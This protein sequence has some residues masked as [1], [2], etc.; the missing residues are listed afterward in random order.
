MRR[1][2][3]FLWTLLV[4]LL[5]TDYIRAE[6]A[7]AEDVEE[8]QGDDAQGDDA[9]G[10]DGAAADEAEEE[11]QGDDAQQDVQDE[12]E[13]Q[14]AEENQEDDDYF[15]Y[16][17]EVCSDAVIQ[18]QDVV[19]SCDSPGTYYY[20]SGK[21]RNNE[22][23]TPGDKVK[24]QIK[25]YIADHDTIQQAGNY[26]ILDVYAS[27]SNTA[28]QHQIYQNAD[29]CSLSSLKSK[30]GKTC[31]Y[32][33][34]Y[35]INTKFYYGEYGSSDEVFLPVIHVGFKSSVDKQVYDFGGANTDLCRG[36]SFVTG[37]QNIKNTFNVALHDFMRNF[38]ILLT[39]IVIMG[40]FIWLLAKRPTSFADAKSRLLS[41]R[42][43]NAS[44]TLSMHNDEEFD[45]R[46]MQ[47]AKG[48]DLVDF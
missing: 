33:G 31:P 8:A 44:R 46:K 35:Q 5:S 2:A 11:V 24:V 16:P 26:A 39:T 23:C 45:F 21:Y 34:Y 3:L 19:A 48:K 37:G 9:Q 41:R 40:A 18:V 30:S 6:D 22:Y 12:E 27:G 28:G 1:P 47:G 43:K 13:E 36:S 25:F 4:L 38:G 29:L 10:D 7:Q 15:G 17:V 20:G 42:H 32:N 14:A